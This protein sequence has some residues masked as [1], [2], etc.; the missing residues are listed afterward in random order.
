MAEQ[1]IRVLDTVPRQVDNSPVSFEVVYDTANPEDPTLTGLGLRIHYNSS[2]ATNLQLSDILNTSLIQQQEQDDTQ[3][4]DGDPETDKF[5]LVAWADVNGNWP[6]DT[7]IPLYTVDF[8]TGTDF[9]GTTFNFTSSS[10]A[11]GRTLDAESFTVIGGPAQVIST[12]PTQ[13]KATPGRTS[14]F[15]VIY[16][17]D[18]LDETLT[19][20]GLRIHYNSEELLNVELTEVLQTSFLQQQEQD[21]TQDFDNDPNTD[22]F[23]LVAWADVNGNWPGESP[24]PLYTFNFDTEDDFTGSTVRFTAS[25]TATGRILDAPP[26][27]IGLNGAPVVEDATFTI[28]ENSAVGTVVGTVVATDPDDD[29]L[30][31]AIT[32]GNFDIDGDGTSAFAIDGNTG[33]I[34]VADTG[35]LNFE[36]TN[37]FNLTV[38][39]TDPLGESDTG[40]I[41][42][43]LTDIPEI[44]VFDPDTY[45]FEIEENSA[46]GTVVGTVV[47]TD[48]DDDPLTFA[49][50][51][52]DP[53]GDGNA[54]FVIDENT[55]EITVNDS[56]DLDF[57]QQP[58]FD[59]QA[60]VTDVEGETDTAN[61]TIDLTDVIEAPIAFNENNILSVFQDVRLEHTIDYA[62]GRDTEQVNE[63]GLFLVDDGEGTIG[64]LSPSDP[65]YIDEILT[66]QKIVFSVL[67]NQGPEVLDL[68]V[69][70]RLLGAEAGQQLAYFIV[71]DTTL[72]NIEAGLASSDSIRV[73]IENFDAE[74]L[75]VAANND[76]S[77]TLSF[78]G[79]ET[80]ITLEASDDPVTLGA[81]LQEQREVIDLTGVAGA[82][83]TLG[84]DGVQS[85]ATF[86]NLIGMYRVDD[87]EGT[88]NGIAPGDAGYLEAAIDRSVGDFV[89]RGGKVA[90]TSAAEFGSV[91]LDGDAIYAPFV[92][93]NGG[94][95]ANFDEFL[96]LNS[97]A[98]PSQ[99]PPE[100]ILETDIVAYF[101]FIAANPDGADH[102]RLLGDNTFGFEDLP[103]GGDNDFNDVVFQ[104]NLA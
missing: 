35:D 89:L 31:F 17:T 47:A 76:G 26:V 53:D 65:D 70:S 80:T 12:N 28:A 43:D 94:K 48:P 63:I 2:E 9:R 27:T 61:V 69:L 91:G 38:E 100:E 37:E 4:F 21:D 95:L 104:V 67:P 29:P 86:D 62:T 93:A 34:T 20:L 73:G 66:G 87:V 50:T 52:I 14:S 45:T 40:A 41:T 78:L 75:D 82:T 1:V 74:A 25:S 54:A 92:I 60:T 49:I 83:A 8:T 3:N 10:T 90:N 30:T 81:D 15:E 39:A 22:K 84:L 42:I 96:D 46:V 88:I 85:K 77:F 59:L 32:S 99:E 102:I 19:G 5:F 7:P 101:P 6:G 98:K 33:E 23:I 68:G 97:N 55:G 56:D 36:D 57:E 58:S 72:D 51:S 16:D 64:G 24:I 11:T 13:P 71:E 79:T 103:G 18:P 44:P